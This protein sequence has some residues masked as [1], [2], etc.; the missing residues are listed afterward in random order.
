MIDNKKVAASYVH[1]EKIIKQHSA[2][3]SLVFGKLAKHKRD[4]IFSIYAFCRVLDDSVDIHK[5]PALLAQYEEKFTRMLDGEYLD[6][7]IF[8]ALA[9]TFQSF[10]MSAT[11]FFQ[12]IAGIRQDSQ[13][14]Q[15]NTDQDLLEYCY[16]VAGTVGEMII[17]ILAT[18]HHQILVNDAIDLGKA[19]Q[20]TNILRDVGED[21]EERRIYFSKTTMERFQ[22]TS[23]DFSEVPSSEYIQMWEYYAKMSNDLYSSGLKNIHLFDC[24][25]Q[26]IVWAAADVYHAILP[27]VRKN[28][29]N[30]QKRAIVSKT[31][32]L[33]ILARISTKPKTR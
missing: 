13:F 10:D 21:W 3:F 17:P 30:C 14:R 27:V 11:P 19:M 5:D 1:C 18:K 24:E 31:E 2:S 16:R 25:C 15:P 33:K 20:L 6:E 22:V 9:Q 23:K 26:K 29:Y 8:I 7:P 4:A 12:L 32:K 28:H